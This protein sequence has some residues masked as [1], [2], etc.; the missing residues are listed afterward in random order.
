M[1]SG[2]DYV[3]MFVISVT[4]STLRM[5]VQINIYFGDGLTT[6]KK[7]SLAIADL[8]GATEVSNRVVCL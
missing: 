7:Y 3:E 1:L 2:F 5:R 6:R 4:I 8:L